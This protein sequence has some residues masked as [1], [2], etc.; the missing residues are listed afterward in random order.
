[1]S[2]HIIVFGGD[3]LAGR[4][5]EVLTDVQINVVTLR[6]PADLGEAG[7]ATAL[8]VV[9][10]S[11]DDAKNLEVALLARHANPQTR[12][13]AR[14]ANPVLRQAMS[15]GNGPGAVLDI[16]DLAAPS[17]VEALLGRTA[18]TIPV[19]AEQF[20]V[21]A[22][23]SDRTA[24]LG[25]L[26]GDL[27][28]V[29]VVC[30]PNSAN[31]GELITCPGPD[32]AIR[33]GDR[34]TVIGR[35]AELAGRGMPVPR[36]AENAPRRRS[37]VVR[38]FDSV[39]AFHDDL[40]PMFYR[41]LAVAA[42]LLIGSTVI[43]RFAY[44]Q[45]VLSWV[46]ALSFAT[47]TLT[48][49]GYGTFDFNEQLTWLRIWGVVMMLSGVATNAILVAFIADVL[50]SRRLSQ[51]TNIERVRHLRNHFVV[52]GIGS[53]GVRVAGML[54]AAGHEVVAIERDENSR[55]L[56]AAAELGVPVILGDATQRATLAEAGAE[57]ARAVAV[58]TDSDMVN[59]ETGIVLHTMRLER[60]PGA[61]PVVL[62]IYDLTLSRAVGQRF[63]FDHVRSTVDLSAPWFIGA[64]IGLEVLGTF[65]VGDASFMAGGVRVRRNSE[66]DGIRVCE[67]S[68]RALVIAIDRD[69]GP[70]ETAPGPDTRLAAGDLAYLVGPYNE[71]LETLR[72]GSAAPPGRARP[73]Q[74][75]G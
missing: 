14:L 1:M 40:N 65:S 23:T 4:I 66:L 24:T 37:R 29:A 60:G 32:F 52:V 74:G 7:L 72:K 19:G 35:P 11:V 68:T 16:A 18:H 3:A 57:H 36:P 38:I 59:I 30:G 49:V 13:V 48:T 50:L 15:D 45:P 41:A 47:E 63:G 56:S 71:L 33:H 9:C 70:A 42:T 6:S 69:G 27:S 54:R 46:D 17:V 55:Y 28:P 73:V 21:S 26:Y 61:G 58:L 51:A 34:V 67:L 10:A 12:V 22:A 44:H 31:P 64:A 75:A 20:V 53:F 25:E 43:L 5:V 39:R 62:R 2:G 8:A